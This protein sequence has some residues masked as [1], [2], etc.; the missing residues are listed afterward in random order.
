MLPMFICITLRNTINIEQ[1]RVYN[2]NEMW[3]QSVY[4]TRMLVLCID[5]FS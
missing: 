5:V 2:V 4:F 1:T 3:V